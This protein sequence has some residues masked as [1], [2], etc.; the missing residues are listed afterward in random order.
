MIESVGLG[1]TVLYK[2]VWKTFPEKMIFEQRFEGVEGLSQA[3]L[4]G[5]NISGKS[6]RSK[7]PGGLCVWIIQGN[8]RRPG[9]WDQCDRRKE[10]KFGWILQAILQTFLWIWWKATGGLLEG[11]FWPQHTDA[12]QYWL[13][14]SIK[15][16]SLRRW[17]TILV[18]FHLTMDYSLPLCLWNNVISKTQDTLLFF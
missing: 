7:G 4:C 11:S 1:V 18:E 9:W 10:D 13:R 15:Y 12:P 14:I 16:Q 2:E 5:K 17:S 6:H 8:A 3:D